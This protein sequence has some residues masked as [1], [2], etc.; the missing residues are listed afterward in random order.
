MSLLE[1]NT[2]DNLLSGEMK[3]A[4]DRE[5][6]LSGQNLSRG[7]LL[8]KI[9]D[10]GA[11]QGKLK[12]CASSASDGSQTPYAILV[13]D[14]DASSADTVADVYKSGQFNEDAI[15]LATGDTI[16]EFKD[17]L[18]DVGIFVKKTQGV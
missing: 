11:S 5:T 17:A 18:R 7:D 10:T 3:I 16:D 15:G 8:G 4:T 1:T 13:D 6:I 12:L 9:T 14:C 2:Y